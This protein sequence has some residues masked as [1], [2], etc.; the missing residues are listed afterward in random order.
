MIRRLATLCFLALAVSAAP[1]IVQGRQAPAAK[2]TV[3]KA[4]AYYHYSLGHVYAELAGAYGSRSEFLD[5][6]IDNYRKAMK[7]DPGAGFL[8]DEL[9]DLYI[10]AGRMREAVLDAKAALKDNP[11]DLDARRIL[12]RIYTRLIG[13]TRQHRVN[14]DMADKAIAQYEKIVAKVPNNKSLWLLLGRLYKLRQDS[15]KAENAYKKVLK[16]DPGNEDALLGLAT[17]YSDLGDQPR[18]AKAL[19]QV[20]GKE[21]VRQ[22]GLS[23]VRPRAVLVLAAEIVELDALL[24]RAVMGVTA[25]HHDA[26]LLG[27][28]IEERR[29]QDEMTDVVGEELQLVAELLV[30]RGQRHDAR[31]TDDRVQRTAEPNDLRGTC[32]HRSWFG[33]LASNGRRLATHLITDRL[34]LFHRARRGDDMNAPLRENAQGLFT[35]TGIGT[36]Q[37]DRASG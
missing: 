10:Q 6:A 9:A 14:E 2:Q 20:V 23:V 27:E 18:A 29:D 25:D 21:D 8:A 15:V 1:A 26:P 19:R 3:D 12:G 24:G 36:R 33:E 22:L 30:E 28:G 34:R 16:L 13:D 5:K 17:V 11:D 4:A 7:A 32:L 35:D 31:V 37:Q